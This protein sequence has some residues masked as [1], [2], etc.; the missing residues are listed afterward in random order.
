M[1][2]VL[3]VLGTFATFGQLCLTRAYAHAPAAQVGPFIYAGPVFASLLDWLLWG[4]LPD[5]VWV[6][7][8]V[9]VAGAAVLALRMRHAPEAPVEA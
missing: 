9:L 1:W 2:A 4:T 3:L 6:V 7:G 8:A 5:R